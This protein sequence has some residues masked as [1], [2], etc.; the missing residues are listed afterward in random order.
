M[1]GKQYDKAIDS[2]TKAIALDSANPVYYSNRAAAYSSKQDHQSAIT[3]AE[4]AV[5]VDP[6]FSKAYHRL[7][8]AHYS[9]GDFPAAA[10]AFRQGLEVDPSNANLKAGLHNAESRI[11]PSPTSSPP[12]LER[13]LGP[14]SPLMPGTGAGA[15]MGGLADMLA[16]M[17]GG[18]GGAGGP[19]GMPDLGSLMNNP[20]MMQMA[21]QMMAN[22]GLERLMQNP[23]VAGMRD[24]V[25]SGGGMP[26]MADIMADP[27]LRDLASQFMGGGGADA[28]GR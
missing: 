2:Y 3:D 4:K 11:V 5:E 18:A 16:G 1:S 22:G 27:T 25:Q 21:Q 26:S 15:G 6:S 7:G 23:A 14:G 8:H 12:P 17:G 20:M 19:A 9:L 24:R 13:D 28:E 10:T